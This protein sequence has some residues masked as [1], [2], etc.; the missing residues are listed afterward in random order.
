MFFKD[1]ITVNTLKE[2]VLKTKDNIDNV[3]YASIIIMVL[4]AISLCI[5]PS[6]TQMVR[7]VT[8]IGIVIFSITALVMQITKE[9][10]VKNVVD[11][12]I[13]LVKTEWY[14]K[15]LRKQYVFLCNFMG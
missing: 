7:N 14:V 4:G 8:V 12:Y 2:R 9:G 3:T 5:F 1:V 13:N 10:Q 15:E 6:M 11:A